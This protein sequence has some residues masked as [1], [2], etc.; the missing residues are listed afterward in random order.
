LID[1]APVLSGLAVASLEVVAGLGTVAIGTLVC[2]FAEPLA[3]WNRRI[4]QAL[5]GKRISPRWERWN[6]YIGRWGGL[7]AALWGIAVLILYA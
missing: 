4:T 1:P 2:V 7:P 6:V 3:N 5:I